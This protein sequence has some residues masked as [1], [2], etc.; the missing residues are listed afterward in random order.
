MPRRRLG[1]AIWTH[2]AAVIFF[3]RLHQIGNT[4]RALLGRK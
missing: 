1:R 2:K 3:D 4:R